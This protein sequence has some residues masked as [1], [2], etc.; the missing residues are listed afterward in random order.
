M[1]WLGL[2]TGGPY[3]GTLLY[4]VQITYSQVC[5]ECLL[6]TQFNIQGYWTSYKTALIAL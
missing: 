2:K 6:V 5:A 1:R 3:C 4:V